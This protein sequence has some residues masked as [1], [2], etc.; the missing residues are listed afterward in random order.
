MEGAELIRGIQGVAGIP[1][2]DDSLSPR[3]WRDIRRAGEGSWPLTRGF[4]R[5]LDDTG[6][7]MLHC[8]MMNHEKMGMM[9]AVEVYDD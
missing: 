1:A 4:S 3:I 5:F 2:G 9:R 7:F 6:V 8:H